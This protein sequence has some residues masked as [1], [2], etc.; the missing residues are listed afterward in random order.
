MSIKYTMNIKQIKAAY[1]EYGIFNVSFEESIMGVASD[2]FNLRLFH[3]EGYLAELIRKLKQDDEICHA[4]ALLS[5]I[6]LSGIQQE[7]IE[8]ALQL[9]QSP[10]T[11]SKTGASKKMFGIRKGLEVIFFSL[12]DARLHKLSEILNNIDSEDTRCFFIFDKEAN[13]QSILSGIRNFNAANSLDEKHV[14]SFSQDFI[15]YNFGRKERQENFHIFTSH[16]NKGEIK[17]II[18]DSTFA[19][20]DKFEV[21]VR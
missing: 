8:R 19:D 9:T 17:N 14:A 6:D 16:F 21:K 3:K 1:W 13:G 18:L 4:V 2:T 15:E 10:V 20:A 5:I 12:P 7:K 11:I